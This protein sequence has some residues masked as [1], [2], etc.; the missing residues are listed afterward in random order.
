LANQIPIDD[1][2]SS[3]IRNTIYLD[4]SNEDNQVLNRLT[5]GKMNNL[6]PKQR[7]IPIDEMELSSFQSKSIKINSTTNDSKKLSSSVRVKR[8]ERA[9]KKLPRL[10]PII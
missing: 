5:V 7:L 8:V 3:I 9:K 1:A 10:E 4:S 2:C 6:L